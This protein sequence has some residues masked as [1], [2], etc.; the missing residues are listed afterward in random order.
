M[1]NYMPSISVRKV[2]WRCND[3]SLEMDLGIRRSCS[4]GCRWQNMS[5]EYE[6]VWVKSL[7]SICLGQICTK[8]WQHCISFINSFDKSTPHDI[9]KYQ[10][11]LNTWRGSIWGDRRQDWSHRISNY[12]NT[13]KYDLS[14][15]T[16]DFIMSISFPKSISAYNY[17]ASRNSILGFSMSFRS[18]RHEFHVSSKFGLSNIIKSTAFKRTMSDEYI[19]QMN[20]FICESIHW[21]DN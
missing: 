9:I 3:L 8:V 21:N 10:N 5:F 17:Y 15:L 19:K 2:L 20:Q 1:K 18:N 12:C 16:R 7:D 13:I 11:V 4:H 6:K 14:S